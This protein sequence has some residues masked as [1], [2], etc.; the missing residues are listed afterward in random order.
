[1][2]CY[3]GLLQALF[4][5]PDV[6]ATVPSSEAE[7]CQNSLGCYRFICS[8]CSE[9]VC[10][11]GT[12]LS[13]HQLCD[14]RR[15]CRDGSDENDCDELSFRLID[16]SELS[17]D[18]QV[19]FKGMWQP[20]VARDPI[21]TRYARVV[22]GFETASGA[23]PWTAAIR[24]KIT[25]AHHCGASVLDRTH[26]ITAAHCFEEDRR[27]SS[28]VVVVGEWD[29]SINEGHEQTLNISRF[30]FYPLY[31]DLFAHDLAIIE[32]AAPMRFDDWTQPIC[33]PPRDFTYQTGRKC[34]VSGWGSLGL[35]YPSRLQAAVLPIID[36]AE[37]MNSSRIYASMS[38]SAF[39]AGYL[40]GGV[41]SCQGDSG[42][43]L[44]C[45][46]EN[47]PYVLAGVISWGDGCAQK[48]QPG[49]YT[50][51]APYLTWIQGIVKF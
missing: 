46:N 50:M 31:E 32:V 33:L 51:V 23:F 5:Q 29:N 1:M 49:I 14:G 45:Q 47:G 35:E 2:S 6:S 4:I 40:H 48:G 11:D 27:V 22:G 7:R 3:T 21:V 36:R 41:D 13:R 44:A 30:N 25:G 38:R 43:P 9:A 39:C 15:D 19:S 10:T 17:G 37:C 24:N 20:T 34:V 8:T 16:G 26:L 42:G 12:C 18:V 28:Y